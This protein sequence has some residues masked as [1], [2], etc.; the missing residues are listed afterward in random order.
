MEKISRVP[1][2]SV[3]NNLMYAMMSKRPNTCPIKWHP[4]PFFHHAQL[5]QIYISS[6]KM[7]QTTMTYSAVFTLAFGFMLVASS[8][9]A[10]APATP[11]FG[12]NPVEIQDCLATIKTHAEICLDEVASL[13]LTFQPNLV[14]PKCCNALAVID[15]KCKIETFSFDSF[16]PSLWIKQSCASTLFTPSHPPTVP[17]ST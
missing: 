9:G 13:V 8:L 4:L 5:V 14:G 10:A 17:S 11:F 1:Y 2:A 3:V 7:V 6:V 15:D 16:L 12:L